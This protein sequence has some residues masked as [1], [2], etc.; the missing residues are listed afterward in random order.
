[1]DTRTWAG[2]LYARSVCVESDDGPHRLGACVCCVHLSISES[3]RRPGIP[4]GL[5]PCRV[6]SRAARRRESRSG[7]NGMGSIDSVMHAEEVDSVLL[8][9]KRAA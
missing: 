4:H 3:C 7:R 6:A 5:D 9:A 1:M 8:L 2:V